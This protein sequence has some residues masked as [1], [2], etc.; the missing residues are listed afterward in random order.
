MER[1]RA[2]FEF[3][4]RGR[5]R[6]HYATS[7]GGGQNG[8]APSRA[9]ALALGIVGRRMAPAQADPRFVLGPRPVFPTI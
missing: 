2:V 1:R 8:Q 4:G 3:D 7:L 6:S 9:H 5:T